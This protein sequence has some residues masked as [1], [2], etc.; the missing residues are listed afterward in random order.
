MMILVQDELIVHDS[1]SL[2]TQIWISVW[3]VVHN[4]FV[5]LDSRWLWEIQCPS[6]VVPDVWWTY[7]QWCKPYSQLNGGP[8]KN[9]HLHL[10]ARLCYSFRVL[11]GII[12]LPNG[13][14]ISPCI[15]PHCGQCFLALRA[16]VQKNVCFVGVMLPFC[17]RKTRVWLVRI[18]WPFRVVGVS[19]GF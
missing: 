5:D 11:G 13:T 6:T 18:T 17:F 7:Y 1:T 15:F 4:K 19:G 3:F 8:A 14:V 9:W 10:K 16:R 12:V 2:H